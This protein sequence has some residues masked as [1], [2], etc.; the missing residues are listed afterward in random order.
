VTLSHWWVK[1]QGLAT[2]DSGARLAIGNINAL[3]IQN[4]QTITGLRKL[5]FNVQIRLFL[6]VA[7]DS[8]LRTL[9]PKHS[10]NF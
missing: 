9:I 2:P 7:K 8:Q 4:H 3:T 5:P 6:S 1:D 10:P